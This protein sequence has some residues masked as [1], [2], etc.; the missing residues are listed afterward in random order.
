M[1]LKLYRS[2]ITKADI[3]SFLFTN[4]ALCIGFYPISEWEFKWYYFKHNNTIYLRIPCTLILIGSRK[5]LNNCSLNK[6]YN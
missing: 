5:L 6:Q 2:R 3:M 4:T 1:R